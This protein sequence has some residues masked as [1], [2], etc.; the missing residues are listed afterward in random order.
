M[1]LLTL[2]DSIRD[3]AQSVGL[4]YTEIEQLSDTNEILENT[5][6]CLLWNY[7]GESFEVGGAIDM[8]LDIYLLDTFYDSEKTETGDYERDFIVTKKNALRNKFIDWLKLMPIDADDYLDVI[9]V[10]TIPIAERLAI[11]GFIA[12]QFR[13]NIRI[14]PSFCLE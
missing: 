11:N 8:G 12:I 4:T 10:D 13:V 9:D 7:Q 6:P 14:K 5:F 1:D 2:R 3:N